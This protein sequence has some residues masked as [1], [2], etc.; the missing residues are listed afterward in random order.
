MN[1]F[2]T[3]EIRVQEILAVTVFQKVHRFQV[4]S[5][6]KI[7]INIE[8]L[9]IFQT[10]CLRSEPYVQYLINTLESIYLISYK[11]SLL[12]FSSNTEI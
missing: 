6:K 4:L 12:K 8:F 1:N 11:V 10:S 3:Y 2:V 5:S 7:F 9:E